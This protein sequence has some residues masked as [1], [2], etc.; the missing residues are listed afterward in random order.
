MLDL[1]IAGGGEI[2]LTNLQNI[3]LVAGNTAERVRFN[4]EA[5]R[6]FELPELVSARRTASHLRNATVLNLDKLVLF[7]RSGGLFDLD[8]NAVVNAPALTTFRDA[9]LTTAGGAAFNAPLLADIENTQLVLR[10]DYTLNTAPLSNIDNARL[11]V[12]GAT[13]F[14]RVTASS[15]TTTRQANDTPFSSPAAG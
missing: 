11:H 6:T 2:D 4:Y 10:P 14:D 9:T 12:E 15:Y 1:N 8:A 3:N 5:N 7:E 13:T